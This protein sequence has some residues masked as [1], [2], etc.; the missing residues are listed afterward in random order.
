TNLNL[1]DMETCYKV[2]RREVIQSIDIEED[3]FGFEPEVTAKVAQGG[4]RVYELG[5]SYRGRTY[6]EGKKIGWRDGVWAVWCILKYS[7]P[8]ARLRALARGLGVA[9]A[10]RS[11]TGPGL[12]AGEPSADG[13]AGRTPAGSGDRSSASAAGTDSAGGTEGDGAPA[14]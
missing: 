1:T 12:R 8:G 3:R 9:P 2:F 7:R 10:P 13:L 4:W 14:G 11:A 6:D 5:I